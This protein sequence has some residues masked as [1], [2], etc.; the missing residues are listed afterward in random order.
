MRAALIIYL[1]LL[2]FLLFIPGTNMPQAQEPG[3]LVMLAPI[4]DTFTYSAEITMVAFVPDSLSDGVQVTTG[5]TVEAPRMEDG[6]A[7]LK[8]HLALGPNLIRLSAKGQDGRSEAVEA[9][10]FRKPRYGR[11]INTSQPAY[12]FHSPSMEMS[13]A[14]CHEMKSYP[15]ETT[16]TGVPN[17]ACWKCHLDKAFQRYTHAQVARGGCF[18]CHELD[19]QPAYSTKEVSG[20]LCTLCH[21]ILEQ[22]VEHEFVHGPVNSG[23]CKVCHDPH[24]SQYENHVRMPVQDLCVMCH[25]SVGREL[26]ADRAHLPF[27]KGDCLR[28]HSPHWSSQLAGL[29]EDPAALCEQC[30]KVQVGTFAHNHPSNVKPSTQSGRELPWL[31]DGK[32]TCISCHNPHASPVDGLLRTTPEEGCNGCHVK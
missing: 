10:I 5:D 32:L 16:T 21:D 15:G 1:C 28:C 8:I 19:S 31:V 3:G 12:E 6:Y 24:G 26:A 7:H 14:G 23:S 22:G 11:G 2:S 29:V 27:S 17:P 9:S 13:C 20:G 30:H 25:E 4:D 18:G